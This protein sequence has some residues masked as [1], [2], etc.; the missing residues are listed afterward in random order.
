MNGSNSSV[1][2]NLL[3]ENPQTFAG[4]LHPHFQR[5][6]PDSGREQAPGVMGGN[7]F[8]HGASKY[9][10]FE[11]FVMRGPDDW[12]RLRT[13]Q[14]DYLRAPK[15][16]ADYIG[17]TETFD[18]DVRAVCARLG[19]PIPDEAPRHNVHTYTGYQDSYTDA[20]RQQVAEVFAK[21]IE[22]FHYDF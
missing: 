7:K 6:D 10:D 19:L 15:R 8:W 4:P 1:T 21:D 17:R 9:A 3:Q 16:R 2:L 20:T 13:P 14:I 5:R 18:A 11:E 12:G 22:L